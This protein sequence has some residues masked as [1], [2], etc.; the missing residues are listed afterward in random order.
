MRHLP[1][2]CMT[3]LLSINSWAITTFTVDSINYAVMDSDKVCVILPNEGLY[4]GD[5]TI[6]STV[7]DSSKTYTVVA[8]NVG[9]FFGCTRLTSISLPP[10]LSV[11][12]DIAFN[13]CSGLTSID[14]PSSVTSIGESAF[15][16]CTGLT[17]ITLPPLVISINASTFNGCTRLTS[18]DIP[19]SVTSMGDYAFYGCTGLTNITIP[20]SVISLGEGVFAGCTSLTSAILPSSV[21]TMGAHTFNGCSRL[22]AVTLPS[23]LT[24]IGESFFAN[25]DSL[26]SITLPP[27]VTSIRNHAFLDCFSLTS[28]TLPTLLDSIGDYA[29]KSCRVLTSIV[30]PSSVTSIGEGAFETCISLTEI[31]IPSSVTSIGTYAFSSCT[32]L[33]S[34]SLPS[35]VSS[36]R[37][38]T[39]Y[40]CAGLKDVSIPSTVTSIGDRAF[41]NCSGLTSIT[42]PDSL[43]SIG[44]NAFT[45]C[46]G[47]TA[48]SLPPSVSSIGYGAFGSCTSLASVY[49]YWEVPI[50]LYDV[51]LNIHPNC[52]LYVPSRT[53]SM[54]QVAYGW[55][56]FANI[57]IN[58]ATYVNHFTAGGLNYEITEPSQVKVVAGPYS[59]NVTIPNFVSSDDTTYRVTAI[60]DAAFLN[61]TG[62]TSNAIPSSVTSIG[63]SAFYGCDSFTSITITRPSSMTSIGRYAFFG[64]TALG[65]ITIHPAVQT[66]GDGAF[67]QCAAKISVDPDNPFYAGWY[68]VLYNKAMTTLLQCPISKQDTLNLPTSVTAIGAKA[69]MG[70]SGLTTLFIPA[71]VTSIGTGAFSGCSGLTAIYS[72]ITSPMNLEDTAFQT[73]SERCVLI[74]PVGAKALYQAAIGWNSISEIKDGSLAT[75]CRIEV[76][77]INY[78][79]TGVSM[80]EVVAGDYTGAIMIPDTVFYY[81]VPY[82]VTTIGENAFYQCTRLTA[83]N[84]PASVTSIGIAAFSGCTELTTFTIPASVTHIGRSAFW[85][86]NHL[87]SLTILSEVISF[88]DYAFISC[89]GL[90]SIKLLH[91]TTPPGL[92]GDALAFIDKTKCVLY[93]PVGSLATY[94]ATDKWKEF[95]SIVEMLPA[96]IP[97][98]KTKGLSMYLNPAQTQVSIDL[99][100]SSINAQLIIYNTLGQTVYAAKI[101]D[102]RMTID[103]TPWPA[104]AYM[105]EVKG[106]PYNSYLVSK[107]LIQ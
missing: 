8:I 59:G 41:F 66:I 7:V 49:V 73:V 106:D 32:G 53:K 72:Y 70:C 52:T 75:G 79:V 26:T 6:P 9:A 35:S 101:I 40:D 1:L 33:T 58:P 38:G 88:G 55:N 78:L 44:K 29:F 45:G 56:Q 97:T 34:I 83:I 18:I 107:F 54:Y 65:S 17:S 98:T 23:S 60:G 12:G 76:G 16:K 48:L 95:L 3:L 61:C 37:S 99:G 27:S 50:E 105:V 39:F 85:G 31:D 63:D 11:I 77:G 68:G 80:L 82:R 90:M 67:L 19:P 92:G 22:N 102:E 5:I 20:S 57:A 21:T 47:L 94:K 89:T 36:I 86:C 64:C 74:V 69:L 103:V 42:L 46:A 24:C 2:L 87:T 96:G 15:A 10:T 14:I 71:S 81:A 13:R 25:C 51:F 84:L 30:L 28:I 93:V 4:A 62:L 43:T 91:A 104:G 100:E